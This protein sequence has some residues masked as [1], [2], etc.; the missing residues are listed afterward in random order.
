MK[1]NRITLSAAIIAVVTLP[2][3]G[4][5][6]RETMEEGAK[7][8]SAHAQAWLARRYF[9][10]DVLGLD[11]NRAR[12]WAKAA[13][14]QGDPLGIFMS[15]QFAG[16]NDV[17]ASLNASAA[18][19]RC[20]PGLK[21]LA[22]EG[23]ADGQAALGFLYLMGLAVPQDAKEALRLFRAAAEQ[24][25]AVGETSLAMMYSDGLGVAKDSAES[26]RWWR[27][28]AERGHAF[29]QTALGVSYVRGEGTPRNVEE[30]AR[31]L[32]MSAE[33]G[34]ADGQYELACLYDRGLL[35]SNNAFAVT[36]Q[37]LGMAARQGHANAKTRLSQMLSARDVDQLISGNKS[38]RSANAT[39]TVPRV[40][41][42]KSTSAASSQT[43][44]S[45]PTPQPLRPANPDS[46]IP[47]A[48]P[49]A[50]AAEGPSDE[51]VRKK[52]SLLFGSGASEFT[53][54]KRGTVVQ[55]AG[56]LIPKGVPVYPIRIE[57]QGHPFDIY[58]FQDEFG[59]WKCNL[60]GTRL[61][62]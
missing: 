11:L 39:T 52:L 56:G 42:G 23:D 24:G 3:S 43:R 31:W 19:T 4:A 34:V 50:D 13:A 6:E 28:A 16:S 5:S 58:F 44:P 33:Q 41:V 20:L 35:R 54:F 25:D 40:N 10:G 48:E 8:G 45:A 7:A 59:D 51:A 12:Q 61:V 53:S 22:D 29:A 47:R 62:Q 38:A 60:K 30:G 2:S 46:S 14:A 15:A 55:G 26:L 17:Q 36:V 27:R 9:Y 1:A 57:K 49:R 18:Y 21:A 37:L 32:R